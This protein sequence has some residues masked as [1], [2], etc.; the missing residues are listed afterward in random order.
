MRLKQLNQI[1]NELTQLVLDIYATVHVL[2]CYYATQAVMTCP[3]IGFDV[4]A[5]CE[6]HNTCGCWQYTHTK[7]CA[8]HDCVIGG[9]NLAASHVSMRPLVSMKLALG[10]KSSALLSAN[11][12]NSKQSA[13]AIYYAHNRHTTGHNM[14]M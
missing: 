11:A 14:V 13:V 8:M 7:L 12:H 2:L 10:K 9:H 6:C 4:H 3:P 5:T 1:C